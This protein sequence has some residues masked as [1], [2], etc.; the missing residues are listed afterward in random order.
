MICFLP[1]VLK[2]RLML[3]KEGT[4][5]AIAAESLLFL[6]YRVWKIDVLK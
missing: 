6:Y 2:D 4:V 1:N 5:G 3:G